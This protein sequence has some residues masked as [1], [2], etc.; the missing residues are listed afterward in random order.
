MPSLTGDVKEFIGVVHQAPAMQT[1]RRHCA[2]T[3]TTRRRGP[4]A[5]KIERRAGAMLRCIADRTQ[6]K[7]QK[8]GPKFRRKSLES[9]AFPGCATAGR[10]RCRID[11]DSASAARPSALLPRASGALRNTAP[12]SAGAWRPR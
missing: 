1:G 8:P 4:D 7:G 11:P 12:A 10:P 2:R 6:T 3:Q 9:L 5:D